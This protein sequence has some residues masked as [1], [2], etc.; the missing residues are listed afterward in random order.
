MAG[1]PE[2]GGGYDK[3]V[4]PGG[5]AWATLEIPL[6]AYEVTARAPGYL[7]ATEPIKVTGSTVTEN[8]AMERATSGPTTGPAP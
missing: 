2:S 4:G 1:N 7:A 5:G 6:G 3:T 8:L